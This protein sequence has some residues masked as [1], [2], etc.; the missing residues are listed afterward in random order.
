MRELVLGASGS[1]KS[2]YAENMLVGKEKLYY[3]ATMRPFSKEGM[4]RVSRHQELRKGKGF[5]TVEQYT[6]IGCLQLEKGA[7][8]L[9]ECMGN[10]VANECFKMADKAEE[11]ILSGVEALSAQCESLVIVTNDVF[12]EVM[13]YPAQTMEYIRVLGAVNC[14][15]A[16]QFGGVLEVSCGIGVKYFATSQ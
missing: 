16:R 10:L 4:E 15:L 7:N 3:I 14:A 6:D 2:A 1:G 12:C 5:Q 8:V 9:L 13:P 11:R